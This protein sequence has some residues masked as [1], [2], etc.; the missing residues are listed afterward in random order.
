MKNFNELTAKDFIEAFKANGTKPIC[1]MYVM[2]SQPKDRDEEQV[3]FTCGISALV[4]LDSEDLNYVD[5]TMAEITL[6][7][8]LKD[9]GIAAT[10]DSI[11]AFI[12]GWDAPESASAKY[13]VDKAA[14]KMGMSI[15]RECFKVLG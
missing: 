10:Q 1:G 7:S 15:R 5:S 8:L 6:L 3:K 2:F 11:E 14:F 9:K 12:G 4:D 13:Y